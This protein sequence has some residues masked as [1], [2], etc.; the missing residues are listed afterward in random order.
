MKQPSSNRQKDMQIN[1]RE[2]KACAFIRTADA[3][4]YA[5]LLGFPKLTYF[6]DKYHKHHHSTN[7][8]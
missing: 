2:Y 6:L 3:R 1:S 5:P 8:Y 4:G 7:F